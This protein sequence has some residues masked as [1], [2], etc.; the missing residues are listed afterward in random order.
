[1]ETDEAADPMLA[2]VLGIAGEVPTAAHHGNQIEQ[3]GR[4]RLGITP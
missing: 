3:S 2:D 1:V 4:L